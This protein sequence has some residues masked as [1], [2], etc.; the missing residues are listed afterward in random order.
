M[1]S[2]EDEARVKDVFYNLISGISGFQTLCT[3]CREGFG[4]VD[5]VSRLSL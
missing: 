4:K 2:R 1:P 5:M 3:D